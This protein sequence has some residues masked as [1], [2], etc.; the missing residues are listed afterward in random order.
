MEQ[1]FAEI[2]PAKKHAMSHRA[3]AFEKLLHSGIFTESL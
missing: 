2:D 3:R 1:T